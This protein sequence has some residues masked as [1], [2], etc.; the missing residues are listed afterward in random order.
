[1]IVELAYEGLL[2]AGHS[3]YVDRYVC[4]LIVWSD[5]ALRTLKDHLVAFVAGEGEA[6]NGFF[7]QHGL[8]CHGLSVFPTETV[9][10]AEAVFL[11]AKP[12]VPCGG[13][14]VLG[15]WVYVEGIDEVFD[16]NAVVG[17]EFL[18]VAMSYLEEARLDDLVA[19]AHAVVELRVGR[20]VGDSIDVV[21][22]DAPV[23]VDLRQ[24]R[25]GHPVVGFAVG[26]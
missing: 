5:S 12:A 7:C 22:V 20:V 24:K 13:A 19:D 3:I 17:E 16:L 15:L 25:C 1:M 4:L 6:V 2:V 9:G 23:E 10:A 14:V 8:S 21:G 11:E 26:G 18:A